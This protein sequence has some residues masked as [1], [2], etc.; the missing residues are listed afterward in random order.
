[1]ARIG[2]AQRGTTLLEVMIVVAILGVVGAL[3]APNLVPLVRMNRLYGQGETTAAFVDATRRRAFG[4]SRCY[5]VLLQGNHLVAE[6]RTEGDCVTNLADGQWVE[7]QRLVPEAN[8]ITV[9]VDSL[10]QAAAPAAD[11]HLVFRP[12]GRLVGDGDINVS[13]SDDGARIVLGDTLEASRGRIVTITAN[14]RICHTGIS[15]PAPALAGPV[16]CP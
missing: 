14:G 5:R 15:L 10:G 16:A 3:A 11:F 12:N 8:T 2:Q 9:T 1:M 13:P 7:V 6:R 4:D